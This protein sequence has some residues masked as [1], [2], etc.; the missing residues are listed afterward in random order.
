[1][2]R[3]ALAAGFVVAI[4]C[5]QWAISSTPTSLATRDAARASYRMKQTD[6]RF[7][8]LNLYSVDRRRSSELFVVPVA[9]AHTVTSPAGSTALGSPQRVQ[10]LRLTLE[11]PPGTYKLAMPGVRPFGLLSVDPP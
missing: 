6:N 4:A 5:I 9:S 2:R 3:A 10:P 11:L 8:D 1:M 7:V